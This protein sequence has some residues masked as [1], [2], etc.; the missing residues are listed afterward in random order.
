[1]SV[2]QDLRMVIKHTPYTE[3][4]CNDAAPLHCLSRCYPYTGNDGYIL[5][6]NR[7]RFDHQVQ[8]SMASYS[9]FIHISR[10]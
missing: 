3:R 2:I 6:E 1:M 5:R 10:Q 7:C 8:P 9:P 4:S